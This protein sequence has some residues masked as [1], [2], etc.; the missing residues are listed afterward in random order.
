MLALA[1]RITF[2]FNYKSE[3]PSRATE[4]HN[5]RPDLLSYKGQSEASVCLKGC[6]HSGL[7]VTPM[8]PAYT[9]PEIARQLEASQATVL[10]SHR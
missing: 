6:L 7:V 3:E 9:P 2:C 1:G 4:N 8:S 5:I 10:V